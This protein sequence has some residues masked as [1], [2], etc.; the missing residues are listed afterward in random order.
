MKKTTYITELYV[1]NSS[2]LRDFLKLSNLLQNNV[3]NF[4]LLEHDNML[5]VYKEK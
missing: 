1:L 5:A 3:R 4:T 2:N